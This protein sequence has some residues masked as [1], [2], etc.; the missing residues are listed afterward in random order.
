MKSLMRVE[1]RMDIE[2]ILKMKLETIEEEPEISDKLD[3]EVPRFSN[4]VKSIS[5][6]VIVKMN[7]SKIKMEKLFTRRVSFKELVFLFVTGIA[8]RG[9]L[10]GLPWH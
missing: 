2:D 1:S 4:H 6:K 5:H 8:S 10:N 7:R 9:G 3:T